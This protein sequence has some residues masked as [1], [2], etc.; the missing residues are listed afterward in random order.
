MLSRQGLN[1]NL[2]FIVSQSNSNTHLS[3]SFV[4]QL[5]S[6]NKALPAS[7][8]FVNLEF[9]QRHLKKKKMTGVNNNSN[10][11]HLSLWHKDKEPAKDTKYR[12]MGAFCMP[13]AGSLRH[14]RAGVATLWSS[15]PMRVKPRPSW[16]N[17]SGADFIK[18]W[19]CQVGPR[20][21]GEAGWWELPVRGARDLPPAGHQSRHHA[22]HC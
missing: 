18:V 22:R 2:C 12:P 9:C 15:R 7:Y 11:S 6:L 5:L 13:W 4:C 3:W 17:E 14:K 21:G 19:C 8:I 1:T 10:K 16:T 20:P